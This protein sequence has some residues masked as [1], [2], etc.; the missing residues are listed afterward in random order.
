MWVKGSA[1]ELKVVLDRIGDQ[2]GL[3]ELVGEVGRCQNRRSAFLWW[4]GYSGVREDWEPALREDRPF[5]GRVD[6][7]I[8]SSAG[9]VLR[10]HPVW[11]KLLR[12]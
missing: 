10:S 11:G 1:Q 4:L 5:Y 6:S 8:L 12:G 7:L 3:Q 9:T 2:V